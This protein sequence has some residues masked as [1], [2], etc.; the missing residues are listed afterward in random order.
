MNTFRIS[1]NTKSLLEFNLNEPNS[2]KKLVR[3]DTD[4]GIYSKFYGNRLKEEKKFEN[5]FK[6]LNKTVY[7]DL[8]NRK[9]IQLEEL[10]NKIKSLM[11]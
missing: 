2:F 8:K 5:L 10:E 4:L 3:Y 6:T 7:S 11:I 1:D 9:K